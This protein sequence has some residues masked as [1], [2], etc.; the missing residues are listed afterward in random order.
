MWSK[1]YS[2]EIEADGTRIELMVTD[3]Q[4]L[5]IVSMGGCGALPQA[6]K[7]PELFSAVVSY[8]GALV[9]FDK[10]KGR[11]FGKLIFNDD[12]QYYAQFNPRAWAEKHQNAIRRGLR[13]RLVI[14]SEDGL[15]KE[16]LDFKA[17]LDRLKISYSWEVVPGVAHCTKCL[18]DQV[19]LAGLK[20]IEASF[21]KK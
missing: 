10:L 7:H 18:Y 11:D 21:G 13:V 9:T 1:K 3:E 17:L 20:F 4:G 14:G 15:L 16:N 12:E 6:F 5:S 19:G 2:L 8:G